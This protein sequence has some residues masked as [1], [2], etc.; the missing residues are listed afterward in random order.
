MGK[1]F[2]VVGWILG[3]VVV[4]V[5]AAVLILPQVVDPNDYKDEIIAKVKQQTG[6]DLVI[7]GRIDLSVFPWLGVETGAVALGNAK[8]FGEKAF[9][10]VE[11]AAVRVK[12]MPLLSRKLE[13]DT[14]GLKGLEL[15]LMR[16]KDGASNWDDLAG[17]DKP[18]PG[19]ADKSGA[20]TDTGG[21]EEGLSA[22]TIGGIDISDARIVWDDQSSGQKITIDQ[23]RLNS[24][25]VVSGEPVDL[26]LGMTLQNKQPAVTAKLDLKGVVAL[27]ESAGVI[28]VSGLKVLLDAEGDALP[29]GAVN[30]VLEAAISA[31]LSGTRFDITGLKLNSGELKLS[32]NLKGQGLDRQPVFSG[33]LDLAEFNLRKWMGDHSMT[34][35]PMADLTT[36]TRLGASVRLTAE[37][38][39]TRMDD[40]NLRLDESQFTGNVTLRGSAVGFNLNLDRIDVDRYLPSGE[41]KAGQPAVAAAPSSTA[42]P[43][44]A[45]DSSSAATGEETLMPVETLRELN[46]DGV[47]NIGR[48]TINKLLAEQIKLTLKAKGGQLNLDQQVGRFYQGGYKG[49]ANLDV[50][51]NTPKSRIDAAATGIQIGP[52]LKDLAGQ[53]RLTGK[54]RFSANLSTLGNS[55]N[56]LKRTLGGK[57]DFRFE[58]GA[59]KGVNVAQS[60]REAKARLS[61][62]PVPKS[63]EPQQTDFSEL[64]GSGVITNG[65]I[66]NQDLLAKSPFLRVNGGGK[67]NLV[68]ESLDY[69]VEGV[70]VSSDKGQ[71]GEGLEELKGVVI[72]V[73]LTGPLASPNYKV[74]WE[75]ALLESQK[76]KVKEKIQ[77][78]IEEKLKGKDIPPDLQDALKG[79]FN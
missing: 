65:V 35:P 57:L 11:S 58:E 47:L 50:R 63:S 16:L 78:K 1:V 42:A 75:K 23:F 14:I 32:G 19:K 5:V 28:D 67:I 68:A 56:A 51:G 71:G 9:A 52:L 21:G 79:L 38:G 77:E 39:A 7:D 20:P 37:G 12:L 25:P 31:A 24:G 49:G 64:S 55:V 29:G 6:R 60:I 13:V 17:T 76:G 54:G 22:L 74:N 70:I 41:E 8:G 72:P 44:P 15:N 66:S 59:V 10:A 2:K 53:E 73:H 3:V 36:L 30:A 4:L 26:A 18:Q 43:A 46:I 40:L 69:K 45:P 62:Q 27:D 61:G 48:L 34:L 33:D